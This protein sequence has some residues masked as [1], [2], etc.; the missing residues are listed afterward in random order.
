MPVHDWTRVFSGTF[1]H[2]HGAWVHRLA[3]ALNA[4]DLPPEFYVLVEQ[5]PKWLIPEHTLA[6]EDAAY[7]LLRRTLTIRH[8]TGRRIVAMIEVVSPGNKDRAPHLEQF[9]NKTVA[10][11]K[12]GI[13]LLVVDIHPRGRYD[14]HGIHSAIW[15]VLAEDLFRLPDDKPLTVAAYL[16]DQM[17]EAFVEPLAVGQPLPDMPLFLTTD[18]YVKAPLEACYME[19]YSRLPTLIKDIVEG[20]A[21]PEEELGE[22][23]ER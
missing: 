18:W 22:D 19:A 20:R 8:R 9:V 13:H 10:M 1:H 6:E 17:P 16:A 21:P 3:D 4:G 15:S 14:P 23:Q 11:L 2:F 5:H 7:R 12:Q